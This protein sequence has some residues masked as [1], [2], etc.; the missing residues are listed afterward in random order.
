MWSNGEVPNP[1]LA[2]W[3]ARRQSAALM[4]GA[5]A[6]AWL[7]VASGP[8]VVRPTG[9]IAVRHAEPANPADPL[10]NPRI[11]VASMLMDQYQLSALEASSQLDHEAWASDQIQK[12]A[13]DEDPGWAGYWIERTGTGTVVLQSTD[14]A[15]I[16]RF[17]SAGYP[18]WVQVRQVKHS[19]STLDRLRSTVRSIVGPGPFLAISMER[20]RV[21]VY[22]PAASPLRRRIHR[23]VP[24]GTGLAVLV[25]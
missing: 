9:R 21:E 25:M 18:D 20:N 15:A 22:V 12:D 13:L 8:D 6:A 5:V 14:R 10:S 2:R 7:A 19:L 24:D 23:A 3:W 16:D 17:R 11:G 1:F 4:L